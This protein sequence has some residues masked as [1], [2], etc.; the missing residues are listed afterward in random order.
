MKPLVQ[1]WLV[2][3]TQIKMVDQKVLLV[4]Y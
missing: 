3:V 2:A 1:H 4:C